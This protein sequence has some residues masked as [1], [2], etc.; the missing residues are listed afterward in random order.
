[1]RTGRPAPRCPGL[2]VVADPDGRL[3][4]EYELRTPRGGDTPVGYAVVDS[5]GQI[6][7]RT[8]DPNAAGRLDEVSTILTATP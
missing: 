6:R 5:K 8:L 7:Y 1:V 3:A 4:R 2:V